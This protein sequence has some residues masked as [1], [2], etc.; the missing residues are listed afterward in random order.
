MW[1]LAWSAV[2]FGLALLEAGAAPAG[3]RGMELIQGPDE[4][5]L[6][7]EQHLFVIGI[8]SYKHWAPLKGAVDEAR[9]IKQV[10]LTRYA[11]TEENTKTL[12]DDEAT[13]INI[14]RQL[15]S[16]SQLLRPED[17]LLLI[18]CGHGEKNTQTEAGFWIPVD[19]GRDRIAQANWIPNSELRDY[20][21]AMKARHVLVIA[22]SCFS[23]L[24]LRGGSAPAITEGYYRRA[25]ELRARQILTSGSDEPVTDR[26]DFGDALCDHLTSNSEPYIDALALFDRVRLRSEKQQALLGQL[27][28]CG[29]ETGG[30]YIFFLRVEFGIRRP[31]PPMAIPEAAQEDVR[32]Y[33]L[34]DS[35]TA[36]PIKAGYAWVTNRFEFVEGGNIKDTL[37]RVTWRIPSSNEIFDW[38]TANE[39]AAR[40]GGRLPTFPELKSLINREQERGDWGLINSRFFPEH[41]RTCRVWTSEKTAFFKRRYV[42][43]KAGNWG[44]A[45]SGD[46]HAVFVVIP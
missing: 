15:D 23:G 26:S 24:L 33:L 5:P 2:V 12:E 14:I 8:N 38:Q 37:L 13:R 1:T 10:L 3:N 19:G 42:D 46:R 21:K 6:S 4:Q 20:V 30:S 29:H 27:A 39:F 22:D 9:K 7:G 35:A 44:D 45:S 28:D 25:Q 32:Q 16:Y 18:Y 17:S 11:F 40:S 41:R 34:A 43:F 36:N 31:V